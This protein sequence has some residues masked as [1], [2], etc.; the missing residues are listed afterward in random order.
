[1]A[2]TL[3]W[4]GKIYLPA[5][6]IPRPGYMVVSCGWYILHFK[7]I[8]D[9]GML[10]PSKSPS[11][12]SLRTV[13]ITVP[14]PFLKELPVR[15][16]RVYLRLEHHVTTSSMSIIDSSCSPIRSAFQF[17]STVENTS[18]CDL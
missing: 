8:R 6:Q 16:S 13:A 3:Q 2:S 12:S 17:G 9:I 1:M 5:E 11:L 14:A 18:L 4:P 10:E 7:G 15:N